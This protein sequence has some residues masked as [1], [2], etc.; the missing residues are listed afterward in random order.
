MIKK[1]IIFK[2]NSKE[3]RLKKLNIKNVTI[4]LKDTKKSEKNKN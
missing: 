3:F 4:L 2:K 1:I